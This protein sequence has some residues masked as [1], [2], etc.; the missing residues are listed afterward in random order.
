L[1]IVMETRPAGIEIGP[2]DSWRSPEEAVQWLK[3]NILTSHTWI[4]ALETSR[5]WVQKAAESGFLTTQDATII[6]DFARLSS[7]SDE[8]SEK[9]TDR[10][11]Q[12][13]DILDKGISPEGLQKAVKRWGQADA[14][15]ITE[16]DEGHT[17]IISRFVYLSRR[18]P[19]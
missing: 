10:A 13:H 19:R 11:A 6:W 15:K 8:M 4:I 12:L 7:V 14:T 5:R 18:W 1:S 16:V 9:V 3:A 17:R 2:I